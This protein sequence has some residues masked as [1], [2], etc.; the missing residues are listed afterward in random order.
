MKVTL[1]TGEVLVFSDENIDDIMT[2][3][4]FGGI[5]YWADVVGIKERKYASV[6]QSNSDVI[7]KGGTLL[8]KDAENDD[9]WELDKKKL[10]NGIKQYCETYSYNDA[11]TL[12]DEMD[13]DTADYIVQFALFNEIVFG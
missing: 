3:A 8:L 4:V 6:V 9:K 13:A 2:T 12:L 5:G 7:S 11:E 10:S 1:S